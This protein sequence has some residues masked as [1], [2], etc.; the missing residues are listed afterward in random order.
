MSLRDSVSAKLEAASEAALRDYY[1][2][3]ARD[4]HDA[5]DRCPRCGATLSCL[6]EAYE[7][8]GNP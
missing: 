1:E 6:C 4:E 8:W 5:D 2:Q 7:F 3:S